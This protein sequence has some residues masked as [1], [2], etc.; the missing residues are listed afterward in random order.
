MRL[1]LV[2]PVLLLSG[3]LSEATRDIAVVSH[4]AAADVTVAIRDV[5]GMEVRN[6]TVALRLDETGM[7]RVPPGTGTYDL[8]AWTPDGRHDETRIHYQGGVGETG[9]VSITLELWPDRLAWVVT[10][11]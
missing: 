4:G 8:W 11:V 7:L 3:C 10:V 9:P 6:S 1:A 5:D 2:L